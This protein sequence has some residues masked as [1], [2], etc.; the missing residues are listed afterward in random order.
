MTNLTH[1]QLVEKVSKAICMVNCHNPDAVLTDNLDHSK[2]EIYVPDA[3]AA[4]ATI[5][6]ATKEPTEAMI[7]AGEKTIC[8]HR[9]T[10][11]GDVIANPQDVFSDM[12]AASPLYPEGK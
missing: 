4:I 1:E 8:V 6:E 5:A 3:R 11:E 7:M 9:W 2:W 10:F 12:H